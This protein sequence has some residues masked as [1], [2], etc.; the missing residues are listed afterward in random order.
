[1]LRF[2]SSSRVSLRALLNLDVKPLPPS[3][4]ERFALRQTGGF[5]YARL[6]LALGVI[7]WHTLNISY[8][9]TPF[10]DF[11]SSPLSLTVR[12]ILPLFFA[13]SGFLVASSLERNPHL[14]T[15][16][17]HRFLRIFPALTVE[18][19]LSAFILGPI[20]TVIALSE[21]FSNPKFLSYFLN[22]AGIIH[23]ELPGVFIGNPLSGIVNGSLWTVPAELEC[24]I[25][26]SILSLVGIFARVRWLVFI[27]VILT[28]ACIVRQ[29]IFDLPLGIA[30]SKYSLVLSFLA[31][32]VVFRV[33][34]RL[35]GG[36]VQG[37]ISL[38]IALGLLLHPVL[39]WIS[40]IF[41]AHAIAALGCTTPKKVPIIFDGDYSYGLYLYAFPIQQAVAEMVGEGNPTEVLIFSVL[42]TSVFACFSW[43]VIEKPTLKLKNSL[44]TWLGGRGI[45]AMIS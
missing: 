19:T 15:F 25:A 30:V 7:L 16:L 21:Y 29:L 35:S 22:V 14:P 41:C 17:W 27:F 24:Y 31:G 1:M 42:A 20:F 43:H 3:L 12:S 40:P 39:V 44:P 4:G 10:E 18:I 36:V 5:D 34:G 37:L 33:R 28:A 13:L 8:G 38:A 45:P 23:Y 2:S 32:V 11:A 9:M 26:L 6:I